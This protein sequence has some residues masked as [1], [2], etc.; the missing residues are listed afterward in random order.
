MS[1]DPILSGYRGRI[2]LK[3][4]L[5]KFIQADLGN[6]TQ[7]FFQTCHGEDLGVRY[8]AFGLETNFCAG[9]PV[10][11]LLTISFYFILQGNWARH[12]HH[13]SSQSQ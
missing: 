1:P 4:I 3:N 8:R 12:F 7:F 2:L 6:L 11:T 5:P 10:D 13:I 9:T